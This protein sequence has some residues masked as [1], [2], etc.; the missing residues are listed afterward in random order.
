[1]TSS[2]NVQVGWQDYL[3]IAFRRRV[4]FITPVV[5]SLVIGVLVSL[6]APRVYQATA[7]IAINSEKLIN[8][9]IQGLAVPTAISDRLQTLREEILSW[10]NLNRLITMHHLD[11]RIPKDR[12]T[13]LEHLVGGLRKD[14]KVKMRGQ[15]LIQVSYEG[16]QPGKVQEIVNSLTDIVIERNAA[17][18]EEEA[19]TA[20]SF[21]EAEL[22]VYRGKLEVS[23]QA[24][25][26]FKEVHMTQM[27]VATALNTQ[28]RELEVTLSNLM[29]DNTEEH[30]RVLDVRRKIEEVRKQRDEEVRR[31][32]EKGVLEGNDP[33][34]HEQLL[35]QLSAQ[36][37]VA[38]QAAASQRTQ[39]AVAAVVQGMEQ[40]GMAVGGPTAVVIGQGEGGQ[41]VQVND[42]AAASLTLA[43]R[44]Q[45]ELSRLTRDYSVNETIYRGMLEKLEKAKITG[46]LGEDDQGGKFTII[47]RARYPL[48]P[49]SPKSVQ[50][51]LIAL[52]AG[53]AVGIL[54]VMIAEYLDQSIQSAE[55][56]LDLLELPVLGTIST[57]LTAED[58]LQRSSRRRHWASPVTWWQQLKVNVAQPV[59]SRV[60]QV[61]VRLGL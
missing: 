31:L 19:Q 56:A 2:N 52:V 4:F 61:L 42:A 28:L 38:A 47:E 23:E 36:Q 55:D 60:D 54:A 27:P 29:I 33:A 8:P 46:R 32:V 17:I 58:V 49:T 40:P 21:I 30:P 6:F 1:M 39:Q 10:T 5:L 7:L 34:M 24:L 15:T 14:I 11:A 3:A 37:Q 48:K 57:I 25:R 26:E 59:W 50:V 45:Q 16:R 12:P 22:N 35:N 9:L 53:L 18:Q 41:T 44:Q 20:I 43:P 51:L 13:A